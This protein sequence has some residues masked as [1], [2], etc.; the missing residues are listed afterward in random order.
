M[1]DESPC[2]EVLHLERAG[3]EI[4]HRTSI[5]PKRGVALPHLR[6]ARFLVFDPNPMNFQLRILECITMPS[7]IEINCL[8]PSSL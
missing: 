1:L 2:L 7:F 4:P 8:L 3:P 6:E 5:L